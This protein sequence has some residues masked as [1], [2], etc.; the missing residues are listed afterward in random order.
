MGGVA[1]SDSVNH[2]QVQVL[3][4]PFLL[5]LACGI[6]NIMVIGIGSLSFKGD[7][8]LEV[9]GSILTAGE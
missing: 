3:R 5:L 6:H 9:A 7:N 8:H 4:I 2:N 1:C